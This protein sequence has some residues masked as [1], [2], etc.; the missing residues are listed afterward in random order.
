MLLMPNKKKIASM[1]ISKKPETQSFVDK[2]ASGG[3]AVSHAGDEP[4]QDDSYAYEQMAHD[5]IAA[6]SSHEPKR[7]VSAL[8]SFFE[9]C[10]ESPHEEGP[11]IEEV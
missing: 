10:D 5:I 9:M 3:I 8:K 11:H 4:E 2:G 6:V 7:L 1:I